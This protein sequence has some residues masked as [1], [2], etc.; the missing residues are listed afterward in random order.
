M[1]I[2]DVLTDVGTRLSNGTLRPKVAKVFPLEKVR[3]AHRIS[4]MTRVGRVRGPLS[5]S[6]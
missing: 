3:E 6:L 5:H 2:T 1:R 4:E